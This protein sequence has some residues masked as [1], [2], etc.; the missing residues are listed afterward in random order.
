MRKENFVQNLGLLDNL[1]AEDRHEIGCESLESHFHKKEEEWGH[2]KAGGTNKGLIFAGIGR[3]C[4]CHNLCP[5]M[6][7]F[8]IIVIIVNINN[9]I[10]N[11]NNISIISNLFFVSITMCG[12]H[13]NH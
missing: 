4:Y 10:V 5:F 6:C 1:V 8:D 7:N 3:H 11:I 2:G 12:G 13:L 9:I